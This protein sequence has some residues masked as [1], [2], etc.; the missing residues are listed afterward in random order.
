MTRTEFLSKYGWKIIQ[1]N[2]DNERLDLFNLMYELQIYWCGCPGHSYKHLF[3]ELSNT[4]NCI[5][6][7]MEAYSYSRCSKTDFNA[8]DIIEEYYGY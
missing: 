5:S 8:K 4:Y 1:F 6:M 3:T 7:A 2:S